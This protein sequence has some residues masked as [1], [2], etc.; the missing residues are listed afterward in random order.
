MDLAGL[1]LPL[2]TSRVLSFI[3]E[4]EAKGLLGSLSFPPN[5]A[6]EGSVAQASEQGGWVRVHQWRDCGQGGSQQAFQP[7]LPG[8]CGALSYGLVKCQL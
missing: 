2:T 6:R 3:C 4:I 8:F 7:S 5:P 1:V